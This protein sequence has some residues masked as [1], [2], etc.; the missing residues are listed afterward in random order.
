M[1]KTRNHFLAPSATNRGVFD[2]G[3]AQQGAE[4]LRIAVLKKDAERYA[5]SGI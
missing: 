3:R 1:W 5:K 2:V 4:V